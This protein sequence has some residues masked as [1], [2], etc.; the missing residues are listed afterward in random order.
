MLQAQSPGRACARGVGRHRQTNLG[1]NRRGL[2]QRVGQTVG[3]TLGEGVGLMPGPSRIAEA[4][5]AILLPPASREEVL[6]DLYERFRSPSRY[7][8]DAL[9]TVPMVV[10]SRIRR[11]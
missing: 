7:A 3:Q 5:V 4:V 11:T 6:G 1:R 8:V 10:I 2:G 9:I